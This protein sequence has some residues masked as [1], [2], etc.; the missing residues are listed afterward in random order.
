MDME[1]LKSAANTAVPSIF[2]FIGGRASS[3]IKGT[4]EEAKDFYIQ[5]IKDSPLPFIE[6][7][8]LILEAPKR[9][10]KMRNEKAIADKAFEHLE[11][12][13]NAKPLDE[14]WEL[15]FWD[16]AENISNEDMQAIWGKIL[17]TEVEKPG[18][19]PKTLIH[20]LSV[21]STEQAKYFE[22]VCNFVFTIKVSA[23]ATNTVPFIDDLNYSK[24]IKLGW[25]AA[26]ANLGLLYKNGGNNFSIQPNFNPVEA[27]Y[28]NKKISITIIGNKLNIGSYCL[29]DE[30]DVLFRSFDREQENFNLEYCEEVLEMIRSQGATVREIQS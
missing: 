21:I 28:F 19:I 20:I 18:S 11:N 17:A 25:L 23:V 10:R 12:C 15:N 27:I 6:K 26:F 3:F 30:G 13:E 9:L 16:K 4:Y 5:G 22:K 14:D 2:S 8:R 1:I 7:E 24:Y 29:S